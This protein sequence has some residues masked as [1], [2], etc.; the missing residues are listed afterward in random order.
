MDM[1][2]YFRIEATELIGRMTADLRELSGA[3][4]ERAEALWREM[5][6]AAHTL[7]GA[8]NV[9]RR[10]EMA[11]RAHDL[12]DAIVARQIEESARI[13]DDLAAQMDGAAPAPSIGT[14]NP[15][16][17]Q[18]DMPRGEDRSTSAETVRV[19]VRTTE[20]LLAALSE[21]E[22]LLSSLRSIAEELKHQRD[23]LSEAARQIRSG[24]GALAQETLSRMGMESRRLEADLGDSTRQL[25]H[26]VAD[27]ERIAQ[28]MRLSPAQEM[29]LR[30][31]RVARRAAEETGLNIACSVSGGDERVD[32][33]LLATAE[34]ALGHMVRNAVVHGLAD[35][36]TGGCV[37]IGVRR[38]GSNLLFFCKDNGIGIDTEHL[39]KQAVLRGWMSE[40][41]ARHASH[42]HLLDML[43]RPG[44]ST[45]LAAGPMAGRGIGLDVARTRAR[46]LG[47]DVTIESKAKVG[48]TVTLRVPETLLALPCMIAE[49]AGRQFAIPL[50]SVE[51]TKKHSPHRTKDMFSVQ[52]APADILDCGPLLGLPHYGE[53]STLLE[54]Q[55]AAGMIHLGVDR[56]VR[57]GDLVIE[58]IPERWQSPD[59]IMGTYVDEDGQA[60]LVLDPFRL[61]RDVIA[62]SI[63]K[64]GQQE[65]LAP[66]LVI[67]DSLTSRTLIA[68]ILSSA[69]YEVETAMSAEEGL[70][71]AQAGSYGLFF[72]DVE[73]PGMDGFEFVR[74]TRSNP[75]LK[76][77]PVV[78]VTSRNLA[79]DRE[80]G[81]SL[82]A[83]EYIVKG[84]FDQNK[85]LSTAAE[86]FRTGQR[87][88]PS[89]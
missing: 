78:M 9:V 63:S 88:V 23:T 52:T 56:V 36:K 7:K 11:R 76:N 27:A 45:R 48:T 33:H 24:A 21:C 2:D 31:E 30:V 75:M 28:S 8:A 58:P 19:E 13:V 74:R 37:E 50:A 71:K 84:N 65:I 62:S 49:I 60:R 47:G 51:Q 53:G 25:Q 15:Q 10:A 89:E 79:G 40:E 20:E 59:W 14:G 41:E 46:K 70:E 5:S 16:K 35:K 18:E 54:V 57:I 1:A 12:E 17:P 3:D 29:L 68:S 64:P 55:S 80:R 42:E 43:A 85:L 34:E 82:G 26:Q 77:V 39:R 73:M 4:A 22:A 81:L 83:S 87:A 86:L 38:D 6:R 72:V 69:G 67:D 61:R 66:V 32:L 44:V